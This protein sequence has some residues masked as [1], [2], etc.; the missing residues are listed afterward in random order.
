MPRDVV[1]KH[2]IR[3]EKPRFRPISGGG[4]ALYGVAKDGLITGRPEFWIRCPSVAL[5]LRAAWERRP[6]RPE[7]PGPRKGPS[8]VVV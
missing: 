1:I 8:P 2:L 7:R 6:P 3:N 5:Q 4:D